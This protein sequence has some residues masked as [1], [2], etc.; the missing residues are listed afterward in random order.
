MCCFLFSTGITNIEQE[1][2]V[3]RARLNR[4]Q[5]QLSAQQ[6]VSQQLSEKITGMAGATVAAI[7]IAADAAY[8]AI[9]AL[10]TAY[11]TAR[12]N[13][14]Q[15]FTQWSSI[16]FGDPQR[17]NLLPDLREAYKAMWT[18]S[19]GLQ[20]ARSLAAVKAAALVIAKAM[21]AL[22]VGAVAAWGASKALEELWEGLISY[23]E[24]D[25][26]Q[27]EADLAQAQADLDDC[28]KKYAG[29]IKCGKC[30]GTDNLNICEGCGGLYC[31][32]CFSSWVEKHEIIS[33]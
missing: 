32:S 20:E 26:T 24:K 2:D 4:L 27:L 14:N 17:L 1:L 16:P 5:F 18:A 23:V 28:L 12:N 33:H 13:Y 15:L 11:A 8:E 21:A 6:Y 10:E 7:G 3:E 25:I 30:V 31:K 22:F 19:I 9:K 29:C